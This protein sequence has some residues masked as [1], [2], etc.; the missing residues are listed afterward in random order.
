MGTFRVARI[1]EHHLS[2]AYD[3][4]GVRARAVKEAVRKVV[5]MVEI[6]ESRA[7][8]IL[9]SLILSPIIYNQR[10]VSLKLNNFE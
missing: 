3:Y 2:K 1:V 9:Q 7:S 8:A 6:V 4:A 10:D 5:V